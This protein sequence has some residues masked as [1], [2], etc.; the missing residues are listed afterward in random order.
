LHLLNPFQ[1]SK[2][3]YYF[4][5][6]KILHLR[7]ELTKDVLAWNL[8]CFMSKTYPDCKDNEKLEITKSGT[9]F[10]NVIKDASDNITQISLVDMISPIKCRYIYSK[11][12]SSNNK[13]EKTMS[14]EERFA[15][16][17]ELSKEDLI[18]EVTEILNSEIHKKKT[19]W[20][21]DKYNNI[22]DNIQ[23]VKEKYSDIKNFDNIVEYLGYRNDDL[24]YSAD[25][26][27]SLTQNIFTIAY[28]FKKNRFI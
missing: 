22:K 25:L 3:S 4:D 23:S 13:K 7:Q 21:L 26:R 28:M 5:T 24:P 16:E 1:N 19:V 18:K 20:S 14:K 11:C 17:S 10:M 8:N 6:K 9:V 15:C 27:D 2:E 12:V